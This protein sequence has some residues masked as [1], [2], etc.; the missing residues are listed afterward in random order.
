M[1]RIAVSF[2]ALLLIFSCNKQ[3]PQEHTVEASLADL[4]IYP[5]LQVSLFAAEPTFSNPTNMAIDAKGRVWVCE[6]YNYRNAL[7]PKNPIRKEGDRIMILEDTDGDGKAD[8]H[9]IFYQGTDIDAALGIC[10][11]GKKV[12]VSCSPNVLVFTDEN[13]D[14]IPDKKEI[15]FKGV[16]GEQ[17]DHG[18]HAFI[19]APDGRLYF[20]M[21]NEGKVL[22]NAG[23]D[24]VVDIHHRKV[25]TNGKPFRQGIALRCAPDGSEAEVLAYN[26]RNPFE[27]TVDP[28]G[29]IWQSDN[30]DD[31]NKST[32][33]NYVMEQGNYGYTDEITGAG[34]NSRRTNM[35]N[36]IPRR[37]WHLNDPGVIPNLLATG[38]GSPAGITWYVGDM[39]PEIFQHSLIHAEA[40]NNVVRAYVLD[41]DGA[42]YSAKIINLLE[43]RQDQWFRPVDVAV[44][45]DGSLFVADWYD[46]GVGGHQV[47]DIDRGRIYR[48]AKPK[49]SYKSPAVNLTTP[50][51]AISALL[52][53]N[54]DMRYRG[55]TALMAFGEQ[56]GPALAKVW[57]SENPAHRA[58]AFWLLSK[59]SSQRQRYFEE[60]LSDRDANI[61]T[62]AMRSARQLNYNVIEI[63]RSLS[64]DESPQVRR[65]AAIALRGI[66]TAEA[67]ALWSELA[68][69]YDGNDRW[70]L[71]ALGIAADGNWDLYFDTWKKK[72]GDKWNTKNNRDIVWRSRS[73]LAL[74]LMV[75]LIESSDE[76]E[77]LR[78]F[79]AFDFHQ[80]PSKQ[81]LLAQVASVSKDEKLLFA[82]KHMDGSKFKM[83]PTLKTTLDRVLDDYKGKLEF[84]E[85]ASAFKLKQKS[86]DLLSLGI[87]Y[88]DSAS[89]KEAVKVLLN[90]GRLDL[91][92]QVFNEK[93]LD[94]AQALVKSLWANMND[95]RALD[96]IQALVLDTTKDLSLRNLAVRTF[97]GPWKS[98]D[99]LL[100]LVKEKKIP[101]DV[102]STA[103]GVF[104]TAWRSNVREDGAKYLQLP[105]SNEGNPLPSIAVLVTKDGNAV[106]GKAVFTEVC[107]NCHRVKNE[108][109]NFGPDLS[110][111]GDKLP[112]EALYAAILYPDQ[113]ISFGY[114]AYRFKLKDGSTAFGRIISETEDKVDLQYINTQQ[115]LD[116]TNIL[117]RV[118]LENSLMPSNLQS[119]MSETDF[120]DLVAFLATLKK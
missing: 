64:R 105:P 30:D 65:E 91:M 59:L 8:K 52:N 107:S 31:G 70:Y 34:W 2:F 110:E 4:K 53:P 104:Q 60:A 117:S 21:G 9:K 114:E 35:E 81:Q 58:Q 45:P 19:F 14:D 94:R 103:A 47:G 49:A 113:G 1:N 115:T 90:W 38:A 48:I 15:L 29:T 66:N 78:Y 27:L 116:K 118:K 100:A 54:A 82:L 40:G 46:P 85:L 55:W 23:G 73:K 22:L 71:E 69:Q 68:V 13:E 3:T 99:R 97:G 51:D 83:S 76:K 72:V 119:Q 80:D 87:Q 89:G 11:L 106:H 74:P 33:I 79:R 111:I 50:D 92:Q 6:A 96:I 77:M 109:V 28:Y 10:I 112:K 32:R 18:V 16:H 101:R 62:T 24:T 12:I 57:K 25:F 56:A 39:L 88:P 75:S 26:F 95:D 120:V 108:G 93:D 84:V 36:E 98:E 102:Q 86:N 43:G 20:N 5:G 42:G 67:A 7:N 41:S 37:H 44:A 17:H 63:I 61:R